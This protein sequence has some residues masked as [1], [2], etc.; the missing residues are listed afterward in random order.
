MTEIILINPPLLA[1]QR[2]GEFADVGTELPNLGLAYLAAFVREKGASVKIIDAPAVGLSH[3]AI[4]KIAQKEKPLIVGLTAATVSV[5]SAAKC[6]KEIREVLSDVK[7][8]IGGPHVSSLPK[9]T[10]EDYP[11]FDVGVVGEG[12]NTLLALYEAF[13]NKKDIYEIPGMVYKKGGEIIITEPAPLIP[14]LDILPMPAWDLLPDLATTYRPGPQSTFRLPS[15]ILFTT[16]GCPF[17]CTFCDRSVFGQKVRSHSAKRVF[18]MMEHLYKT[19]KVVHFAF[20]DE[21]FI[22]DKSRLAEFCDL[23]IDSGLPLTW[24]CQGR[25]DQ[26]VP[27]SILLLMKKAGC[28]QLQFGIETANNKL[29]K[30]IHKGTSVEQIRRALITTKQS[31]ISTKAFFMIGLFGETE[32]TMKN[33]ERFILEAPLDDIMISFFT[34][35]PGSQAFEQVDD[36][37][38]LYGSFDNMSEYEVVFVP[39][40]LSKERVA[41]VRKQIY[42]RFYF[43]ARIILKYITR[44]RYRST[45][46]ILFKSFISTIKALYS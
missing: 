12:E 11:I 21:S 44:L 19:Y 15:T 40:G 33:T 1:K 23:V 37:G 24:V 22:F 30:I 8:I 41:V 10:M 32:Q 28:R 9:K 38:K 3:N 31:G 45:W 20:H 16:R 36:F 5:S 2:Y 43:R 35:F 27:R 39:N 18:E 29:L 14:D 26:P 4:A 13:S 17:K 46:K 25:V 42:R 34:P 6:A 7:I